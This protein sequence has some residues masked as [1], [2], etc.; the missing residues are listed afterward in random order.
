M[1]RTKQPK[2]PARI[3]RLLAAGRKLGKHKPKEVWTTLE[4][5]FLSQLAMAEWEERQ[6]L[7]RLWLGVGLEEAAR[8]EPNFRGVKVLGVKDALEVG[9]L[10]MQAKKAQEKGWRVGLPL[11]HCGVRQP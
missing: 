2:L 8:L 5:Q 10:R 6:R 7:A 4:G 11:S 1:P 9:R 3:Q